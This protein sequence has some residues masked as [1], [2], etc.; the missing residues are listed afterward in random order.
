MIGKSYFLL[1]L[2]QGVHCGPW[3]V[4]APKIVTASEGSCVRIPCTFDHPAWSPLSQVK[5]LKNDKTRGSLVIDSK[6]LS[7]PP[8]LRRT[9]LH[10]RWEVEKDCTLT[11]DGLTHGDVGRYYF[12]MKTKNGEEY[13]GPDGVLVI[14]SDVS[15]LPRI[16]SAEEMVEGRE[17]ELT[18][19][20]KY[21]CPGHLQ[22]TGSDGLDRPTTSETPGTVQ[23]RGRSSRTLRFFASHQDHGRTLR[24]VQ[25]SSQ[26]KT[27][28]QS[29]TLNVKYAPRFVHLTLSPFKPI[30][31]G[32]S[33]TLRC[34]VGDSNPPVT[35][36]RWHQSGLGTTPIRETS[37][38]THR[39]NNVYGYR[40]HWCEAT[41]SVGTA[42]SEKTKLPVYNSYSWAVW[43]PLSLHA[44][45]GSCVIIPCRFR[46]PGSGRRDS[47]ATGI[48]LQNGAYNGIQ[49]Y[50]T[51]WI[52]HYYTGRV[53]FL[54]NMKSR[55]CSLKIRDLKASNSGKYYFR[56]EA[57][58]GQWSDP[59]G[60]RL[61]VSGDLQKP[62][63]TVPESVVDGESVSLTCSVYSYCPE[64]TPV[65][66]WHLPHFSRP[67]ETRTVFKDDRWIYSSTVVYVP[68]FGTTQ[69]AVK[70]TANFGQG[71][72]SAETE[73]SLDVKYAPQYLSITSLNNVD[74]SSVSVKE[75]NSAA[76]LCSVQSF[77]ASNLMWR[78][79]GVTLN[80]SSTNELWLE[81][82]Q[83]TSQLA[84]VYQCVAE[85][86]HG[87]VERNITISVEHKPK[88]SPESRCTQMPEGITCVCK[89]RSNPPAEL[90]WHLPLANLSGNQTHGRFQAWQ[91]ADGQL[92]TGSL[93]LRGGEGEEEAT[94]WCTARNRHGEVSF[95]VYLWVKVRGCTDW[96]TWLLTAGIIF[97]V[98]LAGFFIYKY[99]QQREVVTGKRA[100][101]IQGTTV[102]Y[103]ARSATHQDGGRR[104][105]TPAGVDVGQRQPTNLESPLYSSIQKVFTRDG[106]EA[107]EY[108][109]IR[110]K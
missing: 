74:N 26:G 73:I 81:V 71:T 56:I 3:E 109:E 101:E 19:S 70:C 16:S 97:S 1:A 39:V 31:R 91:V 99:I 40:E 72:P 69:P 88:I 44:R 77:P 95:K 65:F 2:L 58:A 106:D 52:S 17:V 104:M 82:P 7:D 62:V 20:V 68:T 28:V 49:V 50:H 54:G 45:E 6:G 100:S 35:R 37:M 96:R 79:L 36:Y 75:G 98:V 4:R 43:T 90:T 89:A 23:N 12:Q 33:V 108:A 30:N 48:W 29:I 86:E 47:T 67:Q 78:H 38:A 53:E 5:W 51:S 85:N 107:T 21:A 92:V 61:L 34:G 27:L 13:S 60:F 18:C 10:P 105:E 63:I 42:T 32:D 110:F 22:W 80:T 9:Q 8:F 24:C 76:I 46:I 15:N 102:S 87:R 55:N 103:S 57:S 59:I 41:N 25:T 66:E 84:G 11:V 94:V 93:T 83:V 14:I 64:V